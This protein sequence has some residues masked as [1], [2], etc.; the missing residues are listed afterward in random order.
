MTNID[1]ANGIVFQALRI[2]KDSLDDR[3]I[4][5][6]KIFILQEMGI[7]VGYCFNWYIRGP[8]S[9]DLTTYIYNNLDMLKD[10]DFSKYTIS[11]SAEDK[12]K[13]VNSLEKEKPSSLNLAAWFELLASV[14]Y[15]V[16]KWKKD[17]P[18]ECL[19]KYK[20]QFNKEHFDAAMAQLKAIG[21]LS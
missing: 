3:I 2:K 21:C 17:K 15:I 9:P 12:I 20:P 7:D 13:V 14:L 10:Q 1:I 4:S 6:K 19:T 5:Q 16:K 11:K 8:Y 18:F